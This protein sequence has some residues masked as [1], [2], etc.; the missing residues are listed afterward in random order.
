M[1]QTMIDYH[2]LSSFSALMSEGLARASADNLPEEIADAL[3]LAQTESQAIP[4][5]LRDLAQARAEFEALDRTIDRLGRLARQAAGL[6][7]DDQSGREGYHEEFIRLARAIAGLIGRMDYAG[8]RLSLLTR[9]E[10]CAAMIALGRLN[11]VKTIL[12]DRML[13]QET[14]IIEAIRATLEFISAVNQCYPQAM[15]ETPEY[16]RQIASAGLT[17]EDIK[18]GLIPGMRIH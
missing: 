17:V 14:G 1:N 2:R 3:K 8:P 13:E 11:Q 12:T 7:D 18:T 4:S 15:A 6:P 16:L 5:S 9:P 10:A